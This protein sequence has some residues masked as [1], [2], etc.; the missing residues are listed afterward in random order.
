MN[1]RSE[2]WIETSN[3][4]KD[5]GLHYMLD[6]TS[7]Q[8]PQVPGVYSRSFQQHVVLCCLVEDLSFVVEDAS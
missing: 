3:N 4:L 6:V 8:F 5:L 7:V 2:P 1:T